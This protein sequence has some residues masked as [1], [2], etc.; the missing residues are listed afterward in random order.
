M[1]K[2]DSSHPLYDPGLRQVGEAGFDPAAWQS[3]AG[4]IHRYLPC[5]SYAPQIAMIIRIKQ[6]GFL[7]LEARFRDGQE[8][9]AFQ[10][11]LLA[12]CADGRVIIHCISGG[13]DIASDL[14]CTLVTVSDLL[15]REGSNASTQLNLHRHHKLVLFWSS[16]P[17][18]P[19]L[20]Y[21]HFHLCLASCAS[22]A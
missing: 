20:H 10:I 3:Q 9:G 17:S 19:H 13:Q 16:F 12:M 11:V 1:V 21:R 22:S 7:L 8:K 6:T 15:Y 4:E 5:I 14:L 18:P 2:C